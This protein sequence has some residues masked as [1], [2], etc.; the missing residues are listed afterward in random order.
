M[1][2][3]SQ[4]LPNGSRGRTIAILIVVILLGGLARGIY[5]REIMDQPEF[6]HPAIDGAYHDYWARGLAG[7]GWRVPDGYA[8]PRI[9]ERPFFRPP[10][11][12]YLLAGVY[13]LIG[14]TYLAPRIVQM[15]I[16]L[17][18]ILVAFIFARR[19]YGDR[20]AL[21]FA[22]LMA[23]YWGFIYFEGELLGASVA[24]FWTLFLLAVSASWVERFGFWR[25]LLSGLVL[26]V[27]A[28]F[29][30]NLLLFIPVLLIWGMYL[31]RRTQPPGRMSFLLT[32]LFLGIVLALFPGPLRNYLVTGDPVLISAQG[33]MS[34][35][36]GNNEEADGINHYLP[37]YGLISSPFDYPAAVRS[38]EKELGM[39][40]DT[41]SY[42][43]AS[44][45]YAGQAVAFIRAQPGRFCRLLVRKTAL[46]WGPS[47]VTNNR[48][49]SAAR[50]H[51]PLLRV[52]P[53]GFPFCVASFLIG[54]LLILRPEGGSPADERR[55][56]QV[57]LLVVLF[58]GA[59]FFSIL[60]FVSAA[61]YRLPVIPGLLLFSA[62]AVDRLIRLVLLRRYSRVLL[63]L[64]IW[65]GAFFLAALN[66][67]G[68]ESSPAKWH[69][70]HAV[71]Y[72]ASGNPSEAEA[73]YRRALEVRPD[74]HRAGTNLGALLLKR[75][76]TAGAIELFQIV[77]NLQP[78]RAE[79][80]SNLGKALFREGRSE[81][82]IRAIRKAIALDPACV[83][84]YNNLGV[85]LQDRGDEPGAIAALLQAVRIN[86]D[87]GEAHYNLGLVMAKLGRLNE[88]IDY[89][90]AALRINPRAANAHNNLGTALA[91]RGDISG[92]RDHFREAL[93]LEAS[94][95]SAHNNLANILAAEKKYPEAIEQYEQ[96]LR[97]DPDF[98]EARHNLAYTLDLMT[99]PD[100][101]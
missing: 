74:D 92:A 73:E 36:I 50:A 97:I 54:L 30:P 38:L 12:P 85:V 9:R 78:A 4:N 52:I 66:P 5:L 39:E 34:L 49:I 93:R 26:G 75:G 94:L 86:P 17:L 60:P 67:A 72:E 56:R 15:A 84:A 32:G 25:G 91:S 81:E 76:D 10:G 77:V 29:R 22:G 24:V 68:Y 8:D 42:S 7:S 96:A 65:A 89:Y 80:Y 6:Y 79:P 57:T 98:G 27:F 28:L 58:I 31:R 16:G 1:K 99:R 69:Y 18:G 23:G 55:S 100:K 63:W 41:L 87:Y 14:K 35:L 3:L 88:A 62:L 37:G 43:T 21:I 46:F 71:A 83:R 59:Y 51:S 47:E 33:G 11:Y 53:F 45:R 2:L 70:D 44:R 13:L 82:A 95:A 101:K 90:R 48:E 61:R 40:K 19:W 64:A 20:A